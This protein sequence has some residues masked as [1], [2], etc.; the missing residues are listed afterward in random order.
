MSAPLA[1]LWDPACL[2][3]RAGEHHPERPARL[4]ALVARLKTDGLWDRAVHPGVRAA[5]DADLLLCH[6]QAHLALVR[7]ACRLGRPL[8]PDTGVCAASWDAARLSAGAALAGADAVVDGIARRAFALVRPPGHHAEPDRAMGFCLFNTISIAARH[9]IRRRGLARV[10]IVDFD[11]H[12]GNGTQAIFRRDG[13]VLFCSLHQFG[14]N[15]LNP[16][17]AFYPGTGAV[18]E[19]GEGPGTGCLVN[20]PLPAGSAYPAYDRAIRERVGPALEAFRPDM[21]L[22]SAG[23]DAHHED[24]LA[25]L[26]LR[27]EDFGRLTRTLT[28]L[29]DRLCGGRVLSV[30]EGGYHLEALASSAS[31]HTAALLD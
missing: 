2:A 8:E 4:E 13:A 7:E 23:F 26:E 9:L 31:A 12:H 30:L 15:P 27:T 22:L 20:V 10:A 14:P 19:I 21:L 11:A 1:L 3:H 17:A 29:A 6:S 16:A 25:L 18:T 24:P 5:T 28:G